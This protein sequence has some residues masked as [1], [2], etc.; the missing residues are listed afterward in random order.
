MPSS[1]PRSHAHS[2][3]AELFGILVNTSRFKSLGTK[4]LTPGFPL[5]LPFHLPFVFPHAPPR[6]IP[7]SPPLLPYAFKDLFR[8]RVGRGLRAFFLP[9]L[10]PGARLLSSSGF[11]L[12]DFLF[13]G[14]VSPLI[15]IRCEKGFSQMSRHFF[16]PTRDPSH[17]G[18][19]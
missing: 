6:R 1:S 5:R 15:Q 3:A 12:F 14:P 10:S 11:P 8:A 17:C 18:S 2:L 7:R 19:F 13:L 9:L 16:F 4:R